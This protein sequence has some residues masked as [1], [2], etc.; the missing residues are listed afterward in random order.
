MPA[1]EVGRVCV[2]LTGRETGD[3]CVVVDMIDRNFVL[4]TGPRSVTGVKRRRVNI[5]HI[6]PTKEKIKI[7]RGASDD[8]VA[9]ALGVEIK[10]EE[11]KP[12]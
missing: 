1:I 4:I 2:K 3:R 11:K 5:N 12:E 7:K 8:K 9:E 6:K 10:T